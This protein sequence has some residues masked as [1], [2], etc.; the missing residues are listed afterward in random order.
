[1]GIE[2]EEIGHELSAFMAALK[3]GSDYLAELC[4]KYHLDGSTGDSTKT[5]L[6]L[7]KP[8][9]RASSVLDA[10]KGFEGWLSE[11]REYRHP[12]IH[13][14]SPRLKGG[15]IQNTSG[16]IEAVS[17]YPILVP[18]KPMR[19]S[20]DTRLSR[21]FEDPIDEPIGMMTGSKKVS[22]ADENGGEKVLEYELL[23][24][25]GPGYV[26]IEEFLNINL[27]QF[28]SLIVKVIGYVVDSGFRS[29]KSK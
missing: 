8:E 6:R 1:M 15:A 20:L 13:Q 10:W 7:L 26:E 4:I 11:S 14:V 16:G 12:L 3:S 21:M 27:L 5:I 25:A 18:Q 23:S 29:S 22:L 17:I 24:K 28:V 9:S 2:V 19:R